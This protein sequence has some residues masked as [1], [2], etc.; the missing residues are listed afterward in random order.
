MSSVIKFIFERSGT[1]IVKDVLTIKI[2]KESAYIPFKDGDQLNKML[3]FFLYL[4][5]NLESIHSKKIED[6]KKL[7]SI[8]EEFLE[9]FVMSS[10][11][12]YSPSYS[13]NLPLEKY[14]LS[15]DFSISR[16]S[17]G[18][19]A[20]LKSK[21]H[22]LNSLLRHMRNSIAHGRVYMKSKSNRI[23]ILFEDYNRNQRLTFSMLLSLT[24]L[25]KLYFS[26]RRVTNLM[27][28][29]RVNIG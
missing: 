13:K 4:A 9:K 24:D 27:R 26:I 18:V 8:L 6:E 14:G 17:R 11:H 25:K 12:F 1:T 22:E 3:Q 21:E 16:S 19:V 29:A 5:P 2:L 15:S 28:G 7:D 10:Y 20:T 23:Y